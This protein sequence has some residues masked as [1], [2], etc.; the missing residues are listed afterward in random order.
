[1]TFIIIL[2]TLA[3]L[4]FAQFKKVRNNITQSK[5]Y[6][7]INKI[8]GGKAAT[9]S[10]D[11]QKI[12][13]IFQDPSKMKNL[14]STKEFQNLQKSDKFMALVND[15][16]IIKQSEE[17]NILAIAKN[18]KVL[19]LLKDKDLMSQLFAFQKNLINEGLKG[20]AVRLEQ[21]KWND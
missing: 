5:Y 18:P 17:K 7:L 12:A 9:A 2:L 6:A 11:I 1:M 15:P 19:E 13:K 4:K 10:L 3:P 14:E 20:E 8:S 21:Q 16:E